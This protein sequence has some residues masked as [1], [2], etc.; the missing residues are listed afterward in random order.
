MLATEH[1][2]CGGN[3]SILDVFLSWRWGLH[4]APLEEC[5]LYLSGLDNGGVYSAV[6]PLLLFLDT[7]ARY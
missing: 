4:P 5:L 3:P 6:I 7:I 2:A 1:S